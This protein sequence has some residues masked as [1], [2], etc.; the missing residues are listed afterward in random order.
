MKINRYAAGVVA[1]TAPSSSAAASQPRRPAT[2]I[3]VHGASERSAKIAEK[4]GVSVEQLKTDLKAKPAR[5]HRRR[6][7]VRP[8]LVRARDEAER[9]GLGRQPLPGGTPRKGGGSPH[10]A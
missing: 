5:S 8:A 2:E 10:A 7:G 1:V 4:R 3:A 6:R 9:A